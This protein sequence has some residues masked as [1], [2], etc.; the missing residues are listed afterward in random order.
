MNGDREEQPESVQYP[1]YD[2]V[3]SSN[4]LMVFAYLDLMIAQFSSSY[5]GRK[6]SIVS[7]CKHVEN[8]TSNPALQ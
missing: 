5:I 4:D 8:D 6:P 2:G 1:A 7:V 3:L